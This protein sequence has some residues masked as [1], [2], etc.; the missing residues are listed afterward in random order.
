MEEVGFA[1]EAVGAAGCYSHAADRHLFV[2]QRDAVAMS[3]AV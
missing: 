1:A 3:A 2:A